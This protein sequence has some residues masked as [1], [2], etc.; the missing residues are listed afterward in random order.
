MSSI[1]CTKP[2][3]YQE[4]IDVVYFSLVTFTTLGL[5][6]IRPLTN[7]GK[8]LICLEAVMGA[9]M[10]A[11]F[12]VV[13]VRKMAWLWNLLSSTRKICLFALSQITSA[14]VK[15]IFLEESYRIH[16]FMSK[17]KHSYEN[18]NVK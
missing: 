9:F 3:L 14:K 4:I 17:E 6:D 8:A 11:V 10:I 7:L 2:F 13:F 1:F 18:T 16:P 12:V 15:N 5:G